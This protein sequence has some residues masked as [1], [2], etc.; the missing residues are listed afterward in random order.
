ML[1]SSHSEF[2]WHFRTNHQQLN[3][4]VNEGLHVTVMVCYHKYLSEK[5]HVPCLNSI[6]ACVESQVCPQ[7][8]NNNNES[9]AAVSTPLFAIELLG[10]G[11]YKSVHR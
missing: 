2:Q 1:S 8:H 10:S 6:R 7:M 4:Q 11:L 9:T 5:L 3:Y